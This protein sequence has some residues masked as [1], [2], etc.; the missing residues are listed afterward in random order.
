[1][2]KTPSVNH[3]VN[4]NVIDLGAYNAGLS[5]AE[6]KKKYDVKQVA[7]LASNENPFPTSTA[8]LHALQESDNLSHYPDPYCKAL[9]SVLA[10][11]LDVSEKSIVI[12]NGSEDLLSIISRVFTETGDKVMTIVPSFGLHISY[13][14]ACGANMLI[15][16]LTDDLEFDLDK[17]TTMLKTEKPKL[18]FIASPCNPVGCSLN[19]EEVQRIIDSVS[20][21]TL[22]I[23]DEAYYEYAKDDADYPDVLALLKAS[24]KPFVLLRTFSKAYS[25]AGLRIGYGVFFPTQLADYAHKLR[26][27]F[28]VNRLAQSAAIAALQDHD[29]LAKTIAWNNTARAKMMSELQALGLSPQTSKGNYLFFA[30]HWDGT[31]LAQHLLRHGVIVKPWLEQGYEKYI[32]VSIGNEAENAQFVSCLNMI[33]NTPA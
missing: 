6:L 7:K 9:C 30:T 12:G 20:D 15:A 3:L 23:F 21:E 22:L 5:I 2:T 17:I 14:K 18:F 31:E 19:K 26:T 8:V 13:P 25:L 11:E 16:H 1:M 28:N 33:L 27:P 24:E 29:S 4:R 32:R 10:K